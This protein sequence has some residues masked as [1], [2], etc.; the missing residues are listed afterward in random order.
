M[1]E[2]SIYIFAAFMLVREISNMKTKSERK[3][4][5]KLDVA[6]E[7]NELQKAILKMYEE[8]ANDLRKNA[9]NDNNQ[10]PK[11]AYKQSSQQQHTET[12]AQQPEGKTF[13]YVNNPKRV[14]PNQ[15]GTSH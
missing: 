4:K 10:Q 3:S 1:F 8:H 15:A 12:P 11:N 14:V 2:V 7:N 13:R 5:E 9:F 6:K